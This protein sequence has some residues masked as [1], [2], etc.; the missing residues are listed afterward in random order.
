MIIHTNLP[1]YIKLTVQLGQVTAT[2]SMLIHDDFSAKQDHWL[3]FVHWLSWLYDETPIE[4]GCCESV[5][6][7]FQH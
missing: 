1:L 7:Y 5:I 2:S 6:Y 3:K 4:G